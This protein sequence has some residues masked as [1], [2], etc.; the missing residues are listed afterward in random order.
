MAA[1]KSIA[2]NDDF[3]AKL[4]AGETSRGDTLR[5]TT[6]AEIQSARVDIGANPIAN[7]L[8]FLEEIGFSDITLGEIAD[9]GPRRNEFIQA[10]VDKALLE[11]LEQHPLLFRNP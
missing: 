4:K 7:R 5:A 2:F 1:R 3:N 9:G 11:F 6:L 10:L 8:K